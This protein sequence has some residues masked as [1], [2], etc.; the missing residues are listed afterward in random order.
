MKT[1]VEVQELIMKAIDALTVEGRKS[2]GL[3]KAKA[4]AMG[5][6]D[7][8]VA[9][10]ATDLKAKG[11][12]ATIIDKLAKGRTSDLLIKRI[13]AEESLKAHYSKIERL[14]A[15]LNGLQSANRYLDTVSRG[16]NGN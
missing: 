13:V 5:E 11:E 12:P 10:A 4:E 15:Q 16:T 2:E 9:V 3:I 8:M 7:K 14:E 6:Y 1:Q